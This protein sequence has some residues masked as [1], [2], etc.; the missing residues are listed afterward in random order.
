MDKTLDILPLKDWCTSPQEPLFISGPCS[1]ES[2]AQLLTTARELDALGNIKIFRAGVWK[3]RTRPNSFEGIGE[4]AL[5]WLQT[6]KAETSLKTAIEIA[7]PQHVELALEYG[8]DILW[9]GARTV[10]NPF[11]VQ[12]I[13]DSL[14]GVDIPVMVKNPLNPDISLWIGA[15]ERINQAGIKKMIAIHRGFDFFKKSIYRNAP[16]WEIPI[17]LKRRIPNLPILVD[18]SHIAGKRELL[19]DISQKA[20]DLDMDGLMIESHYNPKVAIT[21]AAQQIRPAKLGELIDKLII[22]RQK[23]N[24]D[25]QHKLE[26]Y[27]SE[28]DKLDAELIDILARRF[29]IVDEIGNYKLHNNITIYQTK[30]WTNI[31][32]DRLESG[33]A[34]GIDK[35]FLKKI[36]QLLHKESIARQ[37]RIY[38]K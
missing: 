26:E 4:K 21:D 20:L 19:F 10:V 13:A 14:K 9:I 8:V 34:H 31:L 3:P 30:R 5:E 18:P 38:K 35:G 24:Y 25:F 22:R 36:L 29:D 32:S 17:E 28:I 23:G 1:A 37:A 6:V 11:S 7:K 12:E 2:E 27:R 33:E 15:L 16:M